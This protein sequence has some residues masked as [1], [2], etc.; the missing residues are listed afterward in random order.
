M[1]AITNDL[2]IQN[3]PRSRTV[4]Q[5]NSWP[6]WRRHAASRRVFDRLQLLV[7]AG[8][9]RRSCHRTQRRSFDS[10]TTRKWAL[11]QRNRLGRAGDHARR[12]SAVDDGGG[13]AGQACRRAC[14]RPGRNPF[15]LLGLSFLEPAHATANIFRF[16]PPWYRDDRV[17]KAKSFWSDPPG[18]N[19]VRFEKAASR[20]T[21]S[22][23][24]EPEGD[25]PQRSP[26]APAVVRSPSS[27]GE[28]A[29]MAAPGRRARIWRVVGTLAD[30][31]THLGLSP[32]T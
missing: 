25:R 17:V 22:G 11:Q 14:G 7:E 18:E 15:A 29:G 4:M 6:Y 21:A 3:D 5:S 27:A 9:D 30:Q 16:R 8:P 19:E 10:R 20:S 12:R 13:R 1:G 24:S 31:R 26:Q 28:R 2:W 23:A 32:A